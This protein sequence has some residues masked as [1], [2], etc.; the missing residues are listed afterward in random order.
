MH[1]LYVSSWTLRIS[2]AF[3]MQFVQ[4]WGGGSDSYFEYLIKYARLTNTD[5]PV[6][7]DAWAT[8]VDSSIRTLL[9]VSSLAFH[10]HSRSLSQMAD[11]DRRKSQISRRL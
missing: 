1:T 7:V 6:F 9:V 4:T 2:L 10:R 3:L 8:A 5:D 11:I